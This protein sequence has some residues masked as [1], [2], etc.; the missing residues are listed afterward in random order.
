MQSY[1]DLLV[2][3]NKAE[4]GERAPLF[5]LSSLLV[6]PLNIKNDRMYCGFCSDAELC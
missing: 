5:H 3:D 2:R 1:N 4:G 6:T